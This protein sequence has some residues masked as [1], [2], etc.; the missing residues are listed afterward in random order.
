LVVWC[1]VEVNQY[2]GY[3]SFHGDCWFKQDCI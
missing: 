2:L 3:K 1:A